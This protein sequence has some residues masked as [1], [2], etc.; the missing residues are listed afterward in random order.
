MEMNLKEFFIDFSV[1]SIRV[2]R[3]NELKGTEEAELI[4][5][6][7]TLPHYPE[8]QLEEIYRQPAV[9]EISTQKKVFDKEFNEAVATEK[10][11]I[12]STGYVTFQKD[13]ESYV[14][15]EDGYKL[16]FGTRFHLHFEGEKINGIIWNYFH[17]KNDHSLTFKFLTIRNNPP[18]Q[19]DIHKYIDD[20]EENHRHHWGIFYNGEHLGNVSCSLYD[21]EH[22]WVDISIVIGESKFRGCGLGKLSLSIAID[23]LFTRGKF[24]RIQAGIYSINTSSIRLFESLGF[25]RDNFHRDPVEVDGKLVDVYQYEL[26]RHDW[27]YQNIRKAKILSPPWEN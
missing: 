26:L 23:Y 16:H 21:K 9:I 3:V 20:C 22:K 12:K 18:T 6:G 25:H 13:F 8:I 2:Y 7:K 15:E 10:E 19:E 5:S 17:M 11:N 1:E 4:M 24:E 14:K 27:N